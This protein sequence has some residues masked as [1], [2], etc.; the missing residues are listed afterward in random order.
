M[1]TKTQTA[2]A[3]PEWKWD[4][5]EGIYAQLAGPQNYWD[6]ETVDHNLRNLPDTTVVRRSARDPKSIMHYNFPAQFF[7]NGEKSEC[8]IEPNF[9]IS[10]LD[11]E[12]MGTL[13]PFE[14]AQIAEVL[15]SR[16][17]DN[18]MLLTSLPADTNDIPTEKVRRS[19]AASADN[20]NW[21]M[22]AFI[23][24]PG[25]TSEAYSP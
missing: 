5:P 22:A 14:K 24:N 20:Y 16:A 9:Q 4:G 12:A 25:Y 23:D 1:N 7:L 17:K 13:Y 11:K 19:F 8:Y 2:D 3:S 18:A 6:K 21:T 15:K 10:A